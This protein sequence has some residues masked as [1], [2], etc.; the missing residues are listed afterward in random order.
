MCSKCAMSAIIYIQNCAVNL[1]KTVNCM[2]LSASGDTQRTVMHVTV[3]DENTR[4]KFWQNIDEFMISASSA[5]LHRSNELFLL[6]FDVLIVVDAMID[7]NFSNELQS[8]RACDFFTH[9]RIRYPSSSSPSAAATRE[10]KMWHTKLVQ[11]LK[12]VIHV[13]THAING[14]FTIHKQRDQ[15]GKQQQ[16]KEEKNKIRLENVVYFI[17]LELFYVSKFF[18]VAGGHDYEQWTC[19][20]I[21]L[22]FCTGK[23]IFFPSLSR[24]SL[25]RF[26]FLS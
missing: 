13:E 19:Q 18:G 20:R 25:I 4:L 22:G 15:E 3:D 7:E 10:K 6:N 14:N 26:T 21:H 2:P 9:E 23:S 24:S 8:R 17:S 12:F 1:N 5:P 11:V 16:Q